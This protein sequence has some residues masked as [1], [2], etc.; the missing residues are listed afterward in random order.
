M[1][2]GGLALLLATAGLYGVASYSVSRR[3]HEIG[4]RIAV[5]ATSTGVRVL[6]MRESLAA[7]SI[8]AGVGVAGAVGLGRFLA[9]L[10]DSAT[11]VGPA[12]C[13]VAAL[14]LA[15]TAALAVWQAT[16]RIARLNPIAALRAE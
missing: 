1:F 16:G 7:V 13:A 8:G 5:G 10:M 6:V 9:H 14:I 15:V 3:A 11:G 4:V 2:L 12:A